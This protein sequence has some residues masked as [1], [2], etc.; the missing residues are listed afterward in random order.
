MQGL[1]KGLEVELWYY[2]SLKENNVHKV[3][4]TWISTMT[5]N[6]VITK[7]AERFTYQEG[8]HPIHL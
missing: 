1:P 8:T 7:M 4:T 3:M 6:S 5:L 2:G